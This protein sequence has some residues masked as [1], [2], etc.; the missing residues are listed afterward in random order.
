MIDHILTFADEATAIAALGP[1]GFAA[2]DENRVL[3]WDTSRVIP[4]QAIVKSE[5]VWDN[6]DPKK[7]VLV[8]PEVKEAGFWV[9]VSLVAGSPVLKAMASLSQVRDRD[10]ADL[11]QSYVSDDKGVVGAS[12]LAPVFAGSK[13]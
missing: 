8:S 5:A 9:L 6:K 7:P 11:G 2:Q 1:L 3:R 13:Y 12:R 10:K 4:G